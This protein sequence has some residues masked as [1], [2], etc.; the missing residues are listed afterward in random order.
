MQRY[1]IY[2]RFCQYH[3]N[4]LALKVPFR[5]ELEWGIQLKE[6]IVI[7]MRFPTQYISKY[8][9]TKYN[10]NRDKV[11]CSRRRKHS[12]G[13]ESKAEKAFAITTFQTQPGRFAISSDGG[14]SNHS[15]VDGRVGDVVGSGLS[16]MFITIVSSI[17]AFLMK[18]LTPSFQSTY[19]NVQPFESSHR[20]SETKCSP[21]GVIKYCKACKTWRL[22]TFYSSMNKKM[23]F[24]KRGKQSYF[25]W[26]AQNDPFRMLP[27][28][29]YFPLCLRC[30]T[31]TWNIWNI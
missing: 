15:T 16:R 28:W 5:L 26:P 14:E 21:M 12:L 22:F 29:L 23:N 31:C 20:E 7:L 10:V 3:G 17:S 25:L 1:M 2:S 13:T 11:T 6:K 27:M 8:C 18:P 24:S 30:L 4:S 19:K 9:Q